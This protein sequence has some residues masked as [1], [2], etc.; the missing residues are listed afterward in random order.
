VLISDGLAVQL[1]FVLTSMLFEFFSFR[2]ESLF[3]FGQLTSIGLFSFEKLNQ[4]EDQLVIDGFVADE[5]GS[6]DILFILLKFLV[7]LRHFGLVDHFHVTRD[8]FQFL[9]IVHSFV[10]QLREEIP[11]T[12]DVE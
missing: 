2:C 10:V 5:K 6:R 12:R 8:S 4:V 1:L 3:F 9:G 11:G 7:F